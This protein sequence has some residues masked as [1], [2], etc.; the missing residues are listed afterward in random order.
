MLISLMPSLSSTR[1]ICST[2]T[3]RGDLLKYQHQLSTTTLGMCHPSCKIEIM[4]SEA[5]CLMLGEG[6][7]SRVPVAYVHICTMHVL[8]WSGHYK[9]MNWQNLDVSPKLKLTSKF[10]LGRENT[11]ET[12]KKQPSLHFF[13]A[14]FADG[15]LQYSTMP[16]PVARPRSSVITIAFSNSP[17]T[18]NTNYTIKRQVH[19]W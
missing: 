11:Y 10:A 2:I 4:S 15:F 18:C 16:S 5:S 9:V 1:A 13:S 17:N 6:S 14:K 8:L 12:M 7:V 19:F 3:G